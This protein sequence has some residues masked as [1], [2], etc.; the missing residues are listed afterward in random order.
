MCRQRRQNRLWGSAAGHLV[1]HF[2]VSE[3]D[4]R[5]DPLLPC[6]GLEKGLLEVIEPRKQ[7]KRD[8]KEGLS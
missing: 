7:L 3:R 4:L 2:C 8:L 1:S 5:P 6:L